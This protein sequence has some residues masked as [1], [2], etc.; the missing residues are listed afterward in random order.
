MEEPLTP[1]RIREMFRDFGL[2]HEEERRRVLSQSTTASVGIEEER[3]AA[4]TGAYKVIENH[5][6]VALILMAQTVMLQAAGNQGS[7]GDSIPS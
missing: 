7:M 6:G 4:A 2:E 5:N 1:A 3:Q